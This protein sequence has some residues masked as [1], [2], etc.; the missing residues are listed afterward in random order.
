MP[1]PVGFTMRESSPSCPTSV[2]SRLITAPVRMRD[3]PACKLRACPFRPPPA[4]V[5]EST[6][7]SP[8]TRLE[9]STA[10]GSSM[11]RVEPAPIFRESPI[12]NEPESSTR[13]ALSLN[14]PRSMVT[15]ASFST[16]TVPAAIS[17]PSVTL[18]FPVKL[19]LS[20]DA[21]A[22]EELFSSVKDSVCVSHVRVAPLKV[23]FSA[24]AT[25]LPM[26]HRTTAAR[27]DK[28]DLRSKTER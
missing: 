11:L 2:V 23:R 6:P 9:F 1:S 20:P 17:S 19:T 16:A 27:Q 10:P 7:F 26:V 8:M 21:K 24:Q 28:T 4:P 5:T 14:A 12:S 15:S 13:S 3:A 25:P 18:L 22:E